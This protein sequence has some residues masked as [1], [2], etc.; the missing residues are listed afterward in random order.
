MVI[1]IILIFKLIG[2]Q[3]HVIFGQQQ[4]GKVVAVDLVTKTL[5]LTNNNNNDLQS[6]ANIKQRSRKSKTTF[7]LNLWFFPLWWLWW[8]VLRRAWWEGSRTSWRCSWTGWSRWWWPPCCT[9]ARSSCFANLLLTINDKPDIIIWFNDKDNRDVASLSP[10]VPCL[11]LYSKILWQPSPSSF[12]SLLASALTCLK[13]PYDARISSM[14]SETAV[15]HVQEQLNL[16]R[17]GEVA[18]HR[19]E[20]PVNL[21]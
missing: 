6:N 9:C 3:K 20:H 16:L 8:P 7:G 14:K 19:L 12:S 1:I 18:C 10:P 2:N 13:I 21:V 17:V 5:I 4:A 15:E 11:Q